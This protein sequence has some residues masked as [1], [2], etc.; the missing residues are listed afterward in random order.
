MARESVLTRLR[1]GGLVVVA[2]RLEQQH[3]L[4]VA[5]SLVGVGAPALELTLDEPT[6]AESIA[7]LHK[8]WGDRL[9]IGAGTA[10]R[11]IEAKEAIDAGVDFVVSP[12]FI[13]SVQRLCRDS[14]VLYIPGAASPTDI[15]RILKSGA[16]AVKL[17]PASLITPSYIRDLFEPFRIYQPIFMLTGG[18]DIDKIPPYLAAGVSIVGVGKSILDPEALRTKQ[19]AHIG[20]GAQQVLRVIREAKR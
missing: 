9:L 7:E 6:S 10:L 20:T 16:N 8:Q 11:S 2:R 5:A 3:I 4:S 15:F 19:Y 1:D 17:F 13:P 12:V 14:N 18:L